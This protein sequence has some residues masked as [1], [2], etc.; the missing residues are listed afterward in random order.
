MD[1]NNGRGY[2]FTKIGVWHESLEKLGA[3][4]ELQLDKNY[5]NGWI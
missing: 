3:S 5:W 2:E 1:C 4:V